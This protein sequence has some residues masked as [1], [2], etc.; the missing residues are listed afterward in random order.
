MDKKL[1]DEIVWRK[2]KIGFETPQKNWMQE[3]ALQEYIHEAKRKLF[4]AGILNKAVL[5]KPAEPKAVHDDKNYD[6]RY[7]CAA[8]LL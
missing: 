4:N 6:W 8:Q 5:D 7:L 3:P 1:P 2:E